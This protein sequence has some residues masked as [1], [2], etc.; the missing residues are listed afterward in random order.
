M[1]RHLDG[2]WIMRRAD[3]LNEY[4]ETTIP[5]SVYDT[6]IQVGR[7]PDPYFGENQ[8]GAFEVSKS[9]YIF[10][11]L[12]NADEAIMSCEKIYLRFRGIDTVAEVLFNGEPIGRTEN[13][14]RTYE[15]DI[16]NKIKAGGNTVSVY[17]FSPVEYIRRMQEKEKLWGVNST[18]E[19]FPHIRKAHYM[20]GWD[21]G[22]SLPDMGIW[23]DVELVGVRGGRIESVYVRQKHSRDGVTLTFETKL[24]D[25][26]SNN[27]RMEISLTSP[28][29]AEFLIS[30]ECEAV[31]SGSVKDGSVK[32]EPICNINRPLL[33]HVRGYGKQNLY[34]AKVVLFD[35]EEPVDVQEFNIGLRTVEVCRNKDKDG[36]GEEFCFAVNGTKIFAMGANYIPE[37]QILARRSPER[38]TELLKS[39]VTANYN[40]IRVWGGGFYPDDYF[41]DACDKLGILVWQ[42]FAFACAVYNADTDFCNNVKQELT[43]NIKRLRNHASLGMWCGNNEIESAIL[44]WGIPVTDSQKQG[45]IRLFEKLIPSVV[46]H[47]DPQTFYWASSPSS[48][49]NFDEPSAENKG[50]SHYWDVWHNL[51]PFNDFRKYKFRFCSEYGFESVPEMKTVMSFASK[52]DLNLMSPVMEAHQKCD[53]GTE[54]LMYYLAQMMHY[55]YSFEDLSYAT[56]L[57]QADAVRNCVEHLRRNRGR[58]MGSLYWQVNDSNPVISW[59][60]IDYFG[61]WK[62]LHYYAKK[63]YAPVLCSIDDSDKSRLVVNISNETPNDFV[64]KLHWRVRRNDCT[65]ISEGAENVVVHALSAKDVL[66]LTP[67]HTKLNE[68]MFRDHYIEYTLIEN[69]A[70]I[71]DGTCLL[72]LPKQFRFLKPEIS[73]TIDKIGSVYKLTV[74]SKNFAKG[75][76]LDFEEFDC[77]F[78]D[79]WFDLHG[80]PYNMVLNKSA[81]SEDFSELDLEKMLKIKSYYDIIKSN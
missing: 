64:G 49:G 50:D 54:K 74:T 55:P 2:K 56:Q 20:F 60:S 78:G 33:W 53:A 25:I 43:D 44:G 18:T 14:H 17:I 76:R 72:C 13:M 73:A 27:L 10:E 23:R 42:D 31:K 26:A 6:L 51:K 47:Y 4:F 68:S 3:N 45:Y 34:T 36:D 12:F 21:W 65:V 46:K 7:I 22:P 81:I 38:T 30:D 70:V 15:F 41:Y 37:D 1:I 80:Q 16:T 77:V 69:K 52:D 63:F 48:G 61:R 59:S 71:S 58:C 35:G 29:G 9:D 62:A 67:Q 5:A 8:Y 66:T 11:H 24:S 39:C 79:N 32:I 19:G 28:D 57:V 40:M 75:V